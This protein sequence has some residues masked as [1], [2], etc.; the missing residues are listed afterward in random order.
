[1]SLANKRFIGTSLS[2]TQDVTHNLQ[3]EYEQLTVLTIEEAT[4]DLSGVVPSIRNYVSTAK[5]NCNRDSTLLTLDESTAI[6]LYTMQTTESF[7]GF[8]IA[9]RAG[10]RHNLRPWL[11]Y[12]KLL[13][14]ALNKLPRT[15]ATV[16][17]G[18]NNDECGQYVENELY[19]WW[20]ISS[21]SKNL[22]TVQRFVDENGTLFNIETLYGKDISMFSANPDEEEVVLMPG[23]RVRAKSNSVRFTEHLFL[24]HLQEVY[25]QG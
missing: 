9:L 24:T 3:S 20:G 2:R 15:T 23:T 14:T 7:Y 19:I 1:M 8:N 4:K 17:R 10:N 22:E 11:G 21:C 25:P 5:E 13:I 16:W 18:V 6:Y 12:I